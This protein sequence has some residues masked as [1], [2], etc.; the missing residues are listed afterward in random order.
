VPAEKGRGVRLLAC[1]LLLLL[2]HPSG[3]SLSS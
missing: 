3:Q 2:L 1:L